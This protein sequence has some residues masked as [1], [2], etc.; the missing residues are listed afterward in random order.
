MGTT[1]W[2][3]VSR[4][5]TVSSDPVLLI[6]GD[7]RWENA[8]TVRASDKAT[9]LV[10]CIDHVVASAEHD[11]AVEVLWP[12]QVFVGVRWRLFESGDA[13]SSAGQARAVLSRPVSRP[14]EAALLAMLGTAPSS[15]L[16][17]AELG[18]VIAWASTGPLVLW[19]QGE[20]LVP[21]AVDEALASRPDLTR[22]AHPVAVEL[23]A[24]DPR[25]Y[26]I[27]VTVSKRSGSTNHLDRD[28]LDDLLVRGT[29][30]TH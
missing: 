28:A 5:R 19:R 23:A 30:T 4:S 16:E 20:V 6:A 3:A 25:P 24:T 22:C 7:G 11:V 12:G 29:E 13:L 15:V 9:R 26:W 21:T 1:W 8:C 2:A 27:G 17:F 18:A 10:A 14:V